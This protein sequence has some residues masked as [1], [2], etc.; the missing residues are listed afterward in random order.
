LRNLEVSTF[1]FWVC[2][3]LRVKDVKNPGSSSCQWENTNIN[4][5]LLHFSLFLIQKTIH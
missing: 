3:E 2:F 5:K 4:K 1:Y